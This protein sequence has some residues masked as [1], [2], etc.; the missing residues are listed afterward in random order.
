[1]KSPLTIMLFLLIIPANLVLAGGKGNQAPEL[2]D[3]EISKKKHV[4]P[5]FTPMTDEQTSALQSQV[6]PPC[7]QLLIKSANGISI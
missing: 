7:L 2:A 5:N 4:D 3:A 6:R 1:M